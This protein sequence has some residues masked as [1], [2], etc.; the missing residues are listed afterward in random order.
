[1]SLYGTAT[2]YFDF[3]AG[4]HQE[5]TYWQNMFNLFEI[6]LLYPERDPTLEKGTSGDLVLCCKIMLSR[7]KR[8]YAML[9][10][11]ASEAITAFL[12]R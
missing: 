9:K 10:M 4:E 5:E 7:F 3:D 8:I 1:M 2:A 6:I 11:K 12:G